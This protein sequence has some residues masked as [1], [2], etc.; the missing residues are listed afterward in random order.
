MRCDWIRDGACFTLDR[1]APTGDVVP[2]RKSKNKTFDVV[3]VASFGGQAKLR[4]IHRPSSKRDVSRAAIRM[5]EETTWPVV[6]AEVVDAGKGL[7]RAVG[8]VLTAKADPLSV[9]A[10][11]GWAGDLAGDIADEAAIAA[12][13]AAATAIG[14]LMGLDWETATAE[15][16]AAAEAALAAAFASPPSAMME[17]QLAALVT[18]TAGVVEAVGA[19]MARQPGVAGTA[20]AALNLPGR[21]LGLGFNRFHSW[22][23]RDQYGRISPSLAARARPIVDAGMRDGL[24]RA[25]VR[26]QLESAISTGYQMR[27][28]WQVVAANAVG[29]ARSYTQGASMRAAGVERFRYVAIIDDRTTDICLYC[30]GKIM[31]NGDAMD[32]MDAMLSAGS[33][34]EVMDVHPMAR[35]SSDGRVY[36]EYSDGSQ[37]TLFNVVE[38]GTG[39]GSAGVYSNIASLGE[40]AEAGLGFTPLHHA[41]RTTM[42]AV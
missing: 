31:N 11:D 25:V 26:G 1:L 37:R 16:W 21:E 13:A 10:F 23:V 35:Q 12:D 17:A 18:R 27:G 36:Y 7:L 2:L 8:R 14:I 19:A 29:H 3:L 6:V 32:R 20:G 39:T 5:A 9:D 34:E 15:E 41:C 22:W 30:D 40:M 42:V 38:S 4:Y 24:G 33:P 28:Y